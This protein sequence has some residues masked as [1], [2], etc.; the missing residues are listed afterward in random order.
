MTRT[1]SASPRWASATSSSESS[2]RWRYSTK[3]ARPGSPSTGRKRSARSRKRR[4]FCR[5]TAPAACH[6][7][8]RARMASTRSSTG[9]RRARS[10]RWRRSRSNASSRSRASGDR[11]TA[12]DRSPRASASTVSTCGGGARAGRCGDG[13]RGRR[14]RRPRP[15]RPRPGRCRRSGP[16]GGCGGTGRPGRAGRSGTGARTRR[17]RRATDADGSASTSSHATTSTTSGRSSRPLDPTASTGTRR[18]SR[19]ATMGWISRRLR[20]RTAT[21]AHGPPRDSDVGGDGGRLLGVVG[22]QEALDDRVGG[23]GEGPED[24]L[25]ALV[26]LVLDAVGQGAQRGPEPERGLQLAHRHRGEVVLEAQDVDQV[27]A[28]EAVDRLH[29]VAHR[30]DRRARRV[31]QLEQAALGEV[32][33]LVLVEE[34]HRVAPAFLGGHVG[35][36]GE[37]ADGQPHL[38]AEVEQVALPLAALVGGHH[39]AQLQPGWRP[40][41]ASPSTGPSPSPIGSRPPPSSM[42]TRWSAHREAR[43]RASLRTNSGDRVL[44]RSKRNSSNTANRSCHDWAR[45]RT[46]V[47]GARS[48]SRAWSA[49]R[50]APKEW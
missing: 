30:G 23:V 3:A 13:R 22:G 49:T 27:G 35:V 12:P 31:E 38:V 20:H 46:W 10:A 45:L 17:R 28:P 36:L 11:S 40:C 34:H 15:R 2:R 21:S 41:R 8:V 6:S 19:A 37:E 16:A 5:P 25:Q 1:A 44:R 24:L 42:G 7:P 47:P 4:R 32:G 50:E 26:D 43:A 29:V 39:L 48:S 18:S 14:W 9:R 33:V